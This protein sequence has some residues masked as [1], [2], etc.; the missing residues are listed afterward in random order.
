MKIGREGRAG[1]CDRTKKGQ[2]GHN[3]ELLQP[4]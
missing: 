2:G 3:D 4:G 1:N